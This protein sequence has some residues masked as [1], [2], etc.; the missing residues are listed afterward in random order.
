MG[1]PKKSN[2]ENDDNGDDMNVKIDRILQ[3]LNKWEDSVEKIKDIEKSTAFISEGFENIKKEMREIKEDI[4]KERAENKE[5]KKTVKNQG[6]QI[7][8]LNQNVEYLLAKEKAVCA[9][10]KGISKTVGEDLY[11][12]TKKIANAAGFDIGKVDVKDCYRV[13]LHEK[14]LPTFTIKFVDEVIRDRFVSEGRK[15]RLKLSDL[16]MGGAEPVYINEE[17]TWHARKLY[18]EAIKF[19]KNESLKYCWVKK[20]KVFLRRTQDSEIKWIREI[21]DFLN[22]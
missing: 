6:D 3:K 10:V 19:K 13:K 8:Q 21:N 11:E 16:N 14:A 2:G 7:L 20:G 5:L 9:E 18:Q 22:V 15:K 12:I 17:L 1:R 4:K